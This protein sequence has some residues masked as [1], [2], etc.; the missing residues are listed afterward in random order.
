MT[1]PQQDWPISADR[2]LE[3]TAL[4]PQPARE[5]MQAAYFIC[6]KKGY[7]IDSLADGIGYHTRNVQKLCTGSYDGSLEQVTAKLQ[8]WVAAERKAEE[9]RVLF[10]ETSTSR[11]IMDLCSLAWQY[12]TIGAIWGDSQIGKTHAL[13]KFQRDHEPGTVKLM[14]FPTGVGRIEIMRA[15]AKAAGLPPRE[16]Q[17]GT[18]RSRIFEVVRPEHFFIFDELHEPFL[19]YSDV[20]LKYALEIIREVHDVC[21]CGV[22]LSGT[23]VG[24]DGIANGKFASVFEQLGRRTPFTLQ[25]PKFATRKDLSAIARHFGLGALPAG[26]AADIVTQVVQRN[27]LKAYVIYLESA[28]QLAANRGE[29]LC[30][31]H[32]VNAYDLVRKISASHADKED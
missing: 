12:R 22:L 19:T 16:G 8:E 29:D 27:G 4:L 3:G 23:N 18:I 9:D 2:I 7:S 5:A 13:E 17:L 11:Q 24:R 30:W 10:V 28:R 21:K 20:A 32:V 15:I 6:R 25:L 1:R 14:R 31:Q 26:P